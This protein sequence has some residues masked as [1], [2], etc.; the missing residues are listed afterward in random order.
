MLGCGPGGIQ[1]AILLVLVPQRVCELM[2]D[3][4]VVTTG[5]RAHHFRRQPCAPFW[6]AFL[7][8]GA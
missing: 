2:G 7:S 6:A 4:I 1:G 3:I 5:L 8:A